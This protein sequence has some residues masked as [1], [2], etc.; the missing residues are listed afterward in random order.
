MASS[1]IRTPAFFLAA[2]LEAA[3]PYFIH[4]LGNSLLAVRMKV[5]CGIEDLLGIKIIHLKILRNL[6]NPKHI[7]TLSHAN[8]QKKIKKKKKKKKGPRKFINLKTYLWIIHH[9]VSKT[10]IIR[11]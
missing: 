5:Y 6:L 4:C 3:V 8:K 1:G 9:Y 7:Y 11:E 2:Y 10:L